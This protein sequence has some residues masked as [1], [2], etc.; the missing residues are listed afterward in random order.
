MPNPGPM[1]RPKP[2]P[3]PTPPNRIINSSTAWTIAEMPT[4]ARVRP[5]CGRVVESRTGWWDMKRKA[6]Q[7]LTS[8]VSYCQGRRPRARALPAE[9][10]SQRSSLRAADCHLAARLV[11]DD[12][13]VAS[14]EPGDDLLHVVEVHEA[15]LVDAGGHLRIEPP[16]HLPPRL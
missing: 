11:A 5:A 2:P 1:P 12:E 13:L 14:A 15:R 6:T 3:I 7:G 10:R 4:K 9:A 8:R 16:L